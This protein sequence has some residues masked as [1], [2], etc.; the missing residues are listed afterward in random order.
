VL[1]TARAIDK[2]TVQ[3]AAVLF[4]QE[5]G[6]GG[7]AGV[8]IVQQSDR[9]YIGRVQRRCA[10]R[11][12]G[13]FEATD[14]AWARRGRIIE[15]P[16]ENVAATA[17][18]PMQTLQQAEDRSEQ[19]LAELRA[20][21]ARDGTPE[22]PLGDP[23]V[24]APDPCS[25]LTPDLGPRDTQELD[26]RASFELARRYRPI[27]RF[28]SREPWRP[29]SVE[30]LFREERDG[31]PSHSLCTRA[32]ACRGLR[33]AGDLG[34]AATSQGASTSFVD[35][36][37]DAL[38]G[39]DHRT[40][41]LSLCPGGQPPGVLDCDRGGASAIYF[42]ALQAN[43]RV[44]V[45]YWWFLRYN[46][47][48]RGGASELCRPGAPV[49]CFDHEGDWEGVTVVTAP[50]RPDVAQYVSYASHSGA[51]RYAFE[52][53]ERQGDRP[54]VF[55]ANGS[56]AAYAVPCERRCVQLNRLAGERV[57][58]T[59]ADGKRGWGRNEDR[60][61]FD[62]GPA[63]LLPLP[64]ASGAEWNA[65]PGRWGS[66]ECRRPGGACRL[67]NGPRSPG[68]QDRYLRP[69]CVLTLEE[70]KTC[71]AATA[72][73]PASARPGV[74]TAD[75]CAQFFGESVTVTACDPAVAARALG[76]GEAV[77]APL[78]TVRAGNDTGTSARIPGVAMVAGAPLEPGA[79]ASVTGVIGDSGRALVRVAA[80]DAVR[81]AS[82]TGLGLGGG[83]TATLGVR[84]EERGLSVVLTRPDGTRQSFDAR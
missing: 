13:R 62:D 83:G 54:V 22:P 4:T 81:S 36:A 49:E 17:V 33:G 18:G 80:G 26:E 72:G 51:F 82:V 27:L 11:A 7:I 32:D 43:G 19:L 58:E 67:A 63:C 57:P 71:D 25:G 24:R 76:E 70:L 73:I 56:H 23:R 38:R 15:I 35:L 6:G 34:A 79:T 59:T 42:R 75:D 61:C 28:D 10:R 84:R 21:V 1:T 41:A 16:R 52:A 9:V 31:S 44:Y 5:A 47:F 30:S 53:V 20:R 74:A 12:G 50:G 78:I 64:P 69:W 55:I 39:V 60:P 8:Y 40:P 45:D 48:A 77:D 3:A 46:H 68:L 14:A 65:F 29:L 66:T 2:A 37:G